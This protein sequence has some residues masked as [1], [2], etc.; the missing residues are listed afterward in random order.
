MIKT[1][2]N[3][4]F[5]ASTIVLLVLALSF[6]RQAHAQDSTKSI[7]DLSMNDEFSIEDLMNVKLTV[8]SQSELTQWQTPSCVSVFTREDLDKTGARDL[9]DIIRLIPGFE[10]GADVSG[11]VGIGVRGNWGTEGKVLVL[12]DGMQMNE[13]MYGSS[14]WIGRYDISQIDRIEVVRGA[15]Y[16]YY[17]GF[18]SLGVINIITKK[19][20]DLNGVQL[21]ANYGQLQNTM[22]RATGSVSGGFQHKD[23]DFSVHAY[24][25][26]LH[27]FAGNYSDN[28][29]STMQLNDGSNNLATPLQIKANLEYK[30]WVAKYLHEDF[31]YKT[32]ISFGAN[33]MAPSNVDFST[34]QF[35]L[36]YKWV[37]NDKVTIK[38]QINFNYNRPWT[39][40][41]VKDTLDPGYF[42]Y[43]KSVTRYSQM[44]NANIKLT[45]FLK[46]NLGVGHYQDRAYSVNSN[47]PSYNIT[48]NNVYN[49]FY[50]YAEL[51]LEK[52]QNRS[53]TRL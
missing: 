34:R 7:Q 18:A 1:N 32:R 51:L 31:N 3:R 25:G 15:G 42:F 38:P 14:Q 37:I 12:L 45:S 41:Q 23:L 36:S 30:G 20:K 35:D 11:A 16:A 48:N 50:D 17:N 22:G 10:F 27:R 24:G 5:K 46:L 29:G 39:S 44:I 28:Y 47:V 8:A 43:D 2:C 21:S 40:N 9:I 53:I 13:N 19:G 33:L 6:V 4:R 49:T 26:Q 52:K